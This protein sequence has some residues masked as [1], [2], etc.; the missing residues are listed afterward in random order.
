MYE[1]FGFDG[2]ACR[3]RLLAVLISLVVSCPVIARAVHTVPVIVYGDGNPLNGHEDSREAVAAEPGSGAD[4]VAQLMNAGTIT[5][6]GKFRGTAM[7]V[8]TREFVSDLDGVVLVSAAH[9]IFNLDKNKRFKRCRFYFM[10]WEKPFG[11]GARIDLKTLKM[12]SFDPVQTTS[13]SAFGEGD[14]VFLYVPRP[15]KH[16]QP[17]QSIRLRQFSFSNSESFRQS[18]G[19]FRLVAFDTVAGLIMQSRNCTV[20]ESRADDIGGGSWKGQLLDDC[21]STDGAS[22]GGILALLDQ[23]PFLIGIRN[24]AHW[25]EQVFSV[26]KYPLGPPDGSVWSRY[27]NTNFGRAIDAHLLHQI[28]SFIQTVNQ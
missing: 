6:D 22:G 5:C 12:G 9:V 2:F 3:I 17:D 18:D 23:Q 28:M 26:D 14:W 20:I 11:Y 7:V 27:S 8:D 13:G 15:W 25:S 10:G 1:G 24:G 16:Y 19:E 4:N 21:D